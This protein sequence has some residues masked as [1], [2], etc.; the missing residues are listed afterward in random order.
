MTVFTQARM[1][2]SFI[3]V[4]FLP[5][6]SRFNWHSALTSLRCAARWVGL[7]TPWSDYHRKFSEHL[8]A[9]IDTERNR[10]F[11][12]VMTTL[13][14]CSFR[15][16]SYITHNSVYYIYRIIYYIPSTYLITKVC[17]FWLPPSSYPFPQ[18][19][20]PV[21]ANMISFCITY[22]NFTGYL[23]KS[24]SGWSKES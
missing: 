13:R 10:N 23:C 17:S 3:L 7:H 12:L 24:C 6:V 16:L 4:F 1:K 18:N 14:I 2:G 11:F 9:H 5:A 8:S 19:L 22:P 21:T 20:P 15:P